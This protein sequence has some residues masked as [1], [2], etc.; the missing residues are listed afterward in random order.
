MARPIRGFGVLL[1]AAFACALAAAASGSRA[2]DRYGDRS[3][4][5]AYSTSHGYDSNRHHPS[6]LSH[7]PRDDAARPYAGRAEVRERAETPSVVREE[8]Y[9]QS[10]HEEHAEVRRERASGS[11]LF[12]AYAP[13]TDDSDRT[14]A[15][16]EGYG[17]SRGQE[18]REASDGYASEGDGA[19]AYTSRS[20]GG[21]RAETRYSAREVDIPD[22]VDLCQ[23]CRAKAHAREE[24]R[25]ERRSE[26]EARYRDEQVVAEPETVRLSDAFFIGGGGVGPEFVDFG[27]GGFAVAGGSAGASA[28]ASASA[29]A[30]IS[31]AF[32]GRQQMMPHQ[33]KM[34]GCGCKKY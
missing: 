20:E 22:A 2:A 13:V 15:G 30:R 23:Y 10:R 21:E 28:S 25:E 12:Q 3:D 24:V 14:A 4:D 19:A 18:W 27:G 9:G 1:S 32:A 33:M 6:S 11:Y 7:T 5:E 16:D 26:S 34:K 29:S 31:V 17:A 8:R